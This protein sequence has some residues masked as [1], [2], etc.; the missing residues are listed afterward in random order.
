MEL[1]NVSLIC[2]LTEEKYVK[3]KQ[4][5]RGGQKIR[6]KTQNLKTGKWGRKTIDVVYDVNEKDYANRSALMW[7]VIQRQ[8]DIALELIRQGADIQVKDEFGCTFV[9]LCA[10]GGNYK[11]LKAVL[12]NHCPTFN[13]ML[14]NQPY[15]S[16]ASTPLHIAVHQEHYRVAELLLKAGANPNVRNHDNVL[17]IEWPIAA[18]DGK[19]VRLLLRYGTRSDLPCK[20]GY[21]LLSFSLGNDFPE[22][23]EVSRML[24][25]EEP[26]YDGYKERLENAYEAAIKIGN[27][28]IAEEILDIL[29]DF[30]T[31]PAIVL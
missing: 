1:P 18:S 28:V 29:S 4:I 13:K 16:F 11:L 19:M 22:G 27:A 6:V 3:I 25:L 14:V 21:S 24:L 17:P 2:L 23:H 9:G 12:D 26:K 15:G 8:N 5:L 7:A 31:P 30:P 10:E 20:H